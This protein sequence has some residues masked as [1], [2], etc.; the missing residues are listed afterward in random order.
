MR[1]FEQVVRAAPEQWAWMHD[2]WKTKQDTSLRATE[3]SE[4][5]SEIA[6]ALSETPPRN[7]KR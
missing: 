4:A 7:D 1:Q 2:R 3:G 5:I 6:S